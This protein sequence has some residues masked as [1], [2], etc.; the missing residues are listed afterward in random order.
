MSSPSSAILS[1][2]DAMTLVTQKIML[3]ESY[4]DSSSKGNCSAPEGEA[5]EGKIIISGIIKE[6]RNEKD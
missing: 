4:E 3:G 5:G 6:N 2:G 1:K